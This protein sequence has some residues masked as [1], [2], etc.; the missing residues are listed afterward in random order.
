MLDGC[1]LPIPSVFVYV[2]RTVAAH[3]KLTEQGQRIE[4]V[5]PRVRVSGQGIPSNSACYSARAVWR[6]Q[7]EA[8]TGCG[9]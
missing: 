9:A 3:E 8:L 6:R 7:I 4:Q 5:S 1:V 2:Q